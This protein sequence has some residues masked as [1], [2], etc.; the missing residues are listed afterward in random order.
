MRFILLIYNRLCEL[1]LKKRVQTD[2][3]EVNDFIFSVDIDSSF[4]RHINVYIPENMT[5]E[6]IPFLA[7]VFADTIVEI[8]KGTISQQILQNLKSNIDHYNPKE[9]L[10]LDNIL[11][12]LVY[13]S[14][15]KSNKH[16][17]LVRPSQVFNRP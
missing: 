15:L 3:P 6:N 8:S 9:K 13:K 11:F 2:I 10:F 7:E 5:E 1:L 17:P 16:E 12:S 14:Q 4:N